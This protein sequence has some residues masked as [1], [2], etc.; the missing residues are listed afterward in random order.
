[1]KENPALLRVRMCEKTKYGWK[2]TNG[3]LERHV[4]R[5]DRQVGKLMQQWMKEEDVKEMD[6]L[7][8]RPLWIVS[9]KRVFDA[10]S[11]S[12]QLPTS[13]TV[14]QE[15][16]TDN[17]QISPVERSW[18]AHTCI[19]CRTRP[20]QSR[21]FVARSRSGMTWEIGLLRCI[22]SWSSI[23]AERFANASQNLYGNEP[24]LSTR[25][26]GTTIS[27]IGC[28]S[29]SR[30]GFTTSRVSAMSPAMSR[31]FASANP[32][33]PDYGHF[34]P[35]GTATLEAF[36]GRDAT[37]Q[38]KDGHQSWQECLEAFEYLKIGRVVAER[39][40]ASTELAEFEIVLKDIVY[41][42]HRG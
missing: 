10:T 42:I 21:R 18:N 2:I 14:R 15:S 37:Q 1:M 28:M 26:A 3:D 20:R 19:S 31:L 39:E 40:K 5:A 13:P 27:T 33:P 29:S 24:S 4:K 7:N 11:I 41:N 32:F 17:A 8:G 30:M 38:F 9:G 6:G 34:H 35:G 23:Y 12:P 36:A 25:W 16:A 22:R